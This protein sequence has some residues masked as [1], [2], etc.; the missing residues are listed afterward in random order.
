VIRTQLKKAAGVLLVALLPCLAMPQ[1]AAE[2][3]LEEMVALMAQARAKGLVGIARKTK[4]V[5]ARQAHQGEI[6]VT[7]IKG[8]GKETQ[9][10]PA[11]RT[12]WV[13]RNRCPETGNEQYLVA[14]NQF[15]E[16]YR[17]TSAPVSAHGW[18]EYR[19][20]G[21][22]MRFFTLPSDTEPFTFVAPWGE[23]MVARAAD[24]IV[25]DPR[26]EQDVYR[27]AAASFACSYEIVSAPPGR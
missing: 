19:P 24:A 6:I 18:R 13:V 10:R 25:Q 2:R 17:Q 23:Q 7:A 4:P 3:K 5:D 26:N 22:E 16:R 15:N 21:K 20:I 12:D 1:S 27:V 11:K 14:E 9:S 8:E